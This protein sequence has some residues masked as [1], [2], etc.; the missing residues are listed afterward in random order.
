M[1]LRKHYSTNQGGIN[2]EKHSENQKYISLWSETVPALYRFLILNLKTA[3]GSRFLFPKHLQPVAS[4]YPIDGGILDGGRWLGLRP[5]EVGPLSG[6][7]RTG[8]ALAGRGRR[9][10]V[11]GN[12][13][14]RS[15]E[16]LSISRLI[17]RI[18][19][20][21]PPWGDRPKSHSLG[22]I[23]SMLCGSKHARNHRHFPPLSR[24]LD[25]DARKMLA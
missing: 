21:F 7:R 1:V 5:G 13:V 25:R 2:P 23:L 6:P 19:G 18:N 15:P 12:F 3:P 10:V 17:Q 16:E 22:A 24:R 8:P 20:R 9:E 11:G 14:R 4:E